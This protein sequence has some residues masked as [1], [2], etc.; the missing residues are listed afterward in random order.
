MLA[1]PLLQ[2]SQ[3][4]TRTMGRTVPGQWALG[5]HGSSNTSVIFSRALHT[6]QALSLTL[7]PCGIV[8]AVSCCGGFSQ[9]HGSSSQWEWQESS[10]AAS[11]I[12]Q[13]TWELKEQSASLRHFLGPQSPSSS[14]QFCLRTDSAA[15]EKSATSKITDERGKQ[16]FPLYYWKSLETVPIFSIMG[17]K[18]PCRCMI[19][20]I[21]SAVEWKCCSRRLSLPF[22]GWR[23]T[24][25]FG[26]AAHVPCV[27]ERITEMFPI[28]LSAQGLSKLLTSTP[29]GKRGRPKFSPLFFL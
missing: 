2:P 27:C 23:C 24:C 25:L 19:L 28:A 5:L 13:S 14:L 8:W 17:E 4:L 18:N 12:V 20:F 21:Y 16:D 22:G 15:S 11:G 1:Y 3:Q 7:F 10:R 26:M 9:V 29:L 6:P